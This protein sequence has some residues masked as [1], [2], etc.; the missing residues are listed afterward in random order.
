MRHV[1]PRE[2]EIVLEQTLRLSFSLNGAGNPVQPMFV[3]LLQ[4]LAFCD[5]AWVLGLLEPYTMEAVHG[6]ESD[7]K[8]KVRF[9]ELE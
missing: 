4:K 1:V 9:R 5:E 3:W 6:C 2:R 7:S 8:T